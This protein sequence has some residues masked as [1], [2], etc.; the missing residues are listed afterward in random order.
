MEERLFVGIGI[1]TGEA[2]VGNV[3]AE[4]RMEYTAI[5]TPVNVAF[6]LQ[7]SA[8]P[9]QILLC[10]NTWEIVRDRVQVNPVESVPVKGH[11]P[12]TRAYELVGLVDDA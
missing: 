9:G 4:E 7:Q 1:C 5:G 12:F 10:R 8:Q 6:H 11:Q 3:G 2:V